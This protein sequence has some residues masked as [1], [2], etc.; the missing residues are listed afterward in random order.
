MKKSI[1]LA[2]LLFFLIACNEHNNDRDYSEAI[3][4]TLL[5]RSPYL[6]KNSIYLKK[7]YSL[8][9]TGLSG[10]AFCDNFIA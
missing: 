6:F 2:V 1:F 4:K 8:D 5:E 3:K 9:I 10:V 7:P